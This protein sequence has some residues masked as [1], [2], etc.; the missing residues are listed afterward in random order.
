MP[1]D[2]LNFEEYFYSEISPT[3]T[4]WREFNEKLRSQ[5]EVINAPI[6]TYTYSFTYGLTSVTDAN[7]RTQYYEYDGLGRLVGVRDDEGNL[8][9]Q[10][11]YRYREGELP[12]L[13]EAQGREATESSEPSTPSLTPN[14]E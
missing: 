14:A 5:P 11:E 2:V 6:T 1:E 3:D 12:R 4:L 13:E 7:G 10:H 9:E 8:L